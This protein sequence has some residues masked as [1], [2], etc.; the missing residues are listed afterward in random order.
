[1]IATLV[2]VV[3]SQTPKAEPIKLAA[4]GLSIV[5]MKPE[6]REFLTEHIAQEFAKHQV[7]VVTPK[8]I[9]AVRAYLLSLGPGGASTLD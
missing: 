5:N 6:L 7:S 8:Q 3:L 2:L 9:E 4:P 1:M